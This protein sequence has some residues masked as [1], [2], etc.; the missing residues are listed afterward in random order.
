MQVFTSIAYQTEAF[1]DMT[2]WSSIA[3]KSLVLFKGL[4]LSQV[5]YKRSHFSQIQ[6]NLKKWIHVY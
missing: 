1:K 5:Q 3:K 6:I 4:A 2:L